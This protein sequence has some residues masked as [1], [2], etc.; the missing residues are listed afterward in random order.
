MG[1]QFVVL[2]LLIHLSGCSESTGVE[3]S[4]VGSVTVR[5]STDVDSNVTFICTIESDE[6]VTVRSEVN[7][8]IV[9]VEAEL[10]SI[11]PRDTPLFVVA[12]DQSKTELHLFQAQLQRARAELH[13]RQ[14]ILIRSA[15]S[16]PSEKVQ[17]QHRVTLLEGKLARLESLSEKGLSSR[18]LMDDARLELL[19]EQIRLQQ[20][21][22][23]LAELDST[24]DSVDALNKQVEAY[25]N[26]VAAAEARSKKSVIKAPFDGR[27]LAVD[28]KTGETITGAI[29]GSNGT[30]LGVFGSTSSPYFRCLVNE[31]DVQLLAVGNVGMVKLGIAKRNVGAEI[32]HVSLVGEV[33]TFGEPPS[34]LVKAIPKDPI[35]NVVIGMSVEISIETA[36]SGALSLP[37]NAVNFGDTGP[38]VLVNRSGLIEE[39]KIA[40]GQ[41]TNDKVVILSGLSK[42]DSVVLPTGP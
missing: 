34:Y 19:D 16:L 41:V 20:I 39:R 9:S 27:V 29:D 25:E 10:G 7:G 26:L 21:T 33:N 42:D 2:A 22:A 30:R 6:V 12:D 17:S 11:V 5:P 35:E 32:I 40:V 13:E 18:T 15:T 24:R 4:T 8:T 36:N 1:K 3:P 37:L 31:I 28:V 38:T 14:A 23:K